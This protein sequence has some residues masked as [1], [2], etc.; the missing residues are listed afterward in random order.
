[1][2]HYW[3]IQPSTAPTET[4]EV[5]NDWL[6]CEF[7]RD[8]KNVT[9]RVLEQAAR[10]WNWFKPGCAPI[11]CAAGPCL[12][13]DSQVWVRGGNHARDNDIAT[14]P[15]ATLAEAKEYT[16][17]CVEAVRQC[18]EERGA[19]AHQRSERGGAVWR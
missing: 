14:I 7:T 12:R 1:M 2:T 11:G 13:Y 5:G 10:G 17:R 15:F 8:G 18:A 4:V 9:M 16:A 3:R 6:K 19:V